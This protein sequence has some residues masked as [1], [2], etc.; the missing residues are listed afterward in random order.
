MIEGAVLSLVFVAFC[1]FGYQKCALPFVLIAFFLA[2]LDLPQQDMWQAMRWV[3][4]ALAAGGGILTW[5]WKGQRLRFGLFHQFALWTVIALLL[6]SFVSVNSHM[7][8]LKGGTV[9]LLFLYGSVGARIATV[10]REKAFMKALL[11]ACEVSVYISAVVYGL[12]NYPL[13]GNVNSL[14]AVMGVV[15]WPLLLWEVVVAEP[16]SS[17][18]RK[19]F[20][21]ILCGALLYYSSARAGF[22]GASVST[23]VVLFSLRRYKLTFIAGMLVVLVTIASP[24]RWQALI[25]DAVYN[26][27]YKGFE[28]AGVLASR[29]PNWRQSLERIDENLWFGTGFGVAEGISEQWEG[30]FATQ[31][32]VL[33]VGNSYLVLVEGVGLI[34]SLPFGILLLVLLSRIWQV[35]A[36]VRQGQSHLDYSVPL[37]AVLIAG[38]C[39]A[40]FEDWLFAVGYYLSILF[41]VFAFLLIDRE[42]A[43]GLV[44][45]RAMQPTIQAVPFRQSFY[46][47]Q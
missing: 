28:E 18:H 9:G 24:D 35:F 8:L 41:W 10:G 13:F 46:L 38:L 1:V 5:V 42:D 45:Q 30:G 43:R 22:F 29:T 34:G 17:W 39:H 27:L 23:V 26:A 11:L 6:S 19:S 32:L 44:T 20:A 47:D 37:A 4:L 21:L 12:L 16:S 33:E 31:G 3:A 2:G 40:F 15:V 36:R 14:G 7:T 25:T